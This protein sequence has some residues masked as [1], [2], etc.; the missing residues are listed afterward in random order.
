MEHDLGVE[1]HVHVIDLFMSQKRVTKYCHW[2]YART[3]EWMG[4]DQCISLAPGQKE[5]LTMS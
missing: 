1:Y 4:G 2:T 3:D 5:N